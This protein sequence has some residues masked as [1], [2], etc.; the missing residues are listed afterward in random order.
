MAVPMNKQ[1]D[2]RCQSRKNWILCVQ[3]ILVH[4][5]RKKPMSDMLMD[6]FVITSGDEYSDI[7]SENS[8]DH[9]ILSDE[10]ESNPRAR[11]RPVDDALLSR[12]TTST[13][14]VKAPVK[15]DRFGPP[16]DTVL[17][18]GGSAQGGPGHQDQDIHNDL[19][20]P[21]QQGHV[22]GLFYNYLEATF[23]VSGLLVLWKYLVIW[24]NKW[25]RTRHHLIFTAKKDPKV[26][27]AF[28]QNVFLANCSA[29][30]VIHQSIFK[31]FSW[32]LFC[33]KAWN[34]SNPKTFCLLMEDFGMVGLNCCFSYLIFNDQF[35]IILLKQHNIATL[36]TNIHY[37]VY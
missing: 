6:Y 34:V 20:W 23:S 21:W 7:E 13:G 1:Q 18:N 33:F 3:S 35:N 25:V 26:W 24:L 9:A 30:K 19:Q 28:S 5:P 10:S 2:R 31:I 37:I 27:R 14:I 16:T 17:P 4:C 29:E 32:F 12:P 8:D 36:D 15:H 22:V 11:P